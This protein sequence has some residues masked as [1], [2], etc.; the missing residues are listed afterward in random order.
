MSKLAKTWSGWWPGGHPHGTTLS[1]RG[2][3]HIERDPWCIPPILF[4]FFFASP[5]YSSSTLFHQFST[6]YSILPSATRVL[7][8]STQFPFAILGI[9]GRCTRVSLYSRFTITFSSRSI[10]LHLFFTRGFNWISVKYKYVRTCQKTPTPLRSH[11]CYDPFSLVS[12]FT[13]A[14]LPS[15]PLWPFSFPL[16]KRFHPLLVLAVE[17]ENCQSIN[18]SV[19]AVEIDMFV[20]RLLWSSV[21]TETSDA[22]DSLILLWHI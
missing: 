6:S 4:L 22:V 2:G 16:S 5:F 13:R 15:H 20:A 7:V 17:T 21:E 8:D 19:F 10:I 3:Y 9:C 11:S 1:R 12:T 18:A 14:I